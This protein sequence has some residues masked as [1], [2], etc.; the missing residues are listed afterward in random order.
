MIQ[1]YIDEIKRRREENGI[2]Y[3]QMSYDLMMSSATICNFLNGHNTINAE[4]FLEI[5]EYVGLEIWGTRN[6]R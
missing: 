6:D 4:Y 2:T 1:D 3:E 5:C